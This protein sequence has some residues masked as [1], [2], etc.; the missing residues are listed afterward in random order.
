MRSG[1]TGEERAGTALWHPG[2]VTTISALNWGLVNV[3]VHGS[4]M[5]NG[6]AVAGR[7]GAARASPHTATLRPLP[8]HCS[9]LLSQWGHWACGETAFE[10]SHFTW[11]CSLSS[12]RC[13]HS[14]AV[15]RSAHGAWACSGREERGERRGGEGTGGEETGGDRTGGEL[16]WICCRSA[17]LSQNAG[18]SLLPATALGRRS[19]EM[20]AARIS[21]AGTWQKAGLCPPSHRLC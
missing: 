2:L 16:P 5:A 8:R 17:S 12:A 15:P 18:S 3:Q 20:G 7:A 21:Q 14:S 13:V 9:S 11:S 19:C 10:N 1:H 6:T 4:A